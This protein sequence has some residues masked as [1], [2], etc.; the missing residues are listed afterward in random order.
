MK[1]VCESWV[2]THPSKE[3]SIQTNSRLVSYLSSRGRNAQRNSLPKQI[4]L[5][6]NLGSLGTE[7][8]HPAPPG[9]A[10]LGLLPTQLHHPFHGSFHRE[11]LSLDDFGSM[12]LIP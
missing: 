6:I 7:V 12:L 2:R 8:Q 4:C 1:G 9:N 10:P 3:T 11:A 5:V